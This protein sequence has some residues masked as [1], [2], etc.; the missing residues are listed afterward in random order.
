MTVREECLPPAGVDLDRL[1]K[2]T[3]KRIV[4]RLEQLPEDP[5]DPLLPAISD[6]E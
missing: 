2:P 5:C 3:Q 6:C 4:R 1:D